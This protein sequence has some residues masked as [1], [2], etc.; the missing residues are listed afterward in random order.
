MLHMPRWF[1]PPLRVRLGFRSRARIRG[2]R[3]VAVPR[4]IR[5]EA[6]HEAQLHDRHLPLRSR[7][8]QSS[9][10]VSEAWPDPNDR[11]HLCSNGTA[12]AVASTVTEM[13]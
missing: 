3:A 5:D 8:R 12:A 10:S 9:R 2:L 13:A 6:R 4:T 11:F 1:G 7:A